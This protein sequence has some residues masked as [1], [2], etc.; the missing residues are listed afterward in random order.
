MCQKLQKERGS[1]IKRA[2]PAV[3]RSR[4]YRMFGLIDVSK[5]NRRIKYLKYK[6]YPS[7]E[8]CV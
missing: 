2:I 8:E 1:P 7:C 3:I 4:S 5:N 6:S